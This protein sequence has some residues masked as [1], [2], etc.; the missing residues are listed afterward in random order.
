MLVDYDEVLTRLTEA[1]GRH[2]RL[3]P[4]ILN[5]PG[6]SVAIK[7]DPDFYLALRPSFAELLGKWAAVVPAR[8][9]ETLA[10]TGNLVL[11]PDKRRYEEPLLVFEEDSPAVLRLAADFVPAAFIDRAVTMYGGEP[12][13]LAVSGLRLVATQQ[14]A[15]EAFF[16]RTTPLRSLAFG[17]PQGTP[18]AR[19]LP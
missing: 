8:V 9:E 10:R 4:S 2:Y 14:R 13:P 5:V 15:L 18:V 6:V 12:G 17:N 1:L 16:D 3:A 19:P 7:I 11:G